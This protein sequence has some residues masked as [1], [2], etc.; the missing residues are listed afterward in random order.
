MNMRNW[1]LFLLVF[2]SLH[3]VEANEESIFLHFPIL[4]EVETPIGK[5]VAYEPDSEEM[6][7]SAA[8][9]KSLYIEAFL[10]TYTKY[11]RESG[12]TES[13]E[14]WLGLKENLTLARWL[15]NGFDEEY[16]EYF[17]GDKKFI[18]LRNYEGALIAW[19][20]YSPLNE[21]GAIYLSQCSLEA[22]Y[23]R[24]GVAS[25]VF[26]QGLKQDQ[27]QKI[28]PGAKE[29]NLVTRKINVAAQ[30]LYTKAGFILDETMDPSIYGSC[31]GDR[32]VCYKRSLEQ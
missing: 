24:Q 22:K 27:I 5:V 21:K 11:H 10:T 1:L 8:F 4:L 16:R 23:R 31:Y 28:F 3:L 14:K 30:H 7:K 29:I 32:Y 6:H 26:F 18:F 25:S 17:L 20:S 13:I 9:I 2:F 12:S 19:M 15:E